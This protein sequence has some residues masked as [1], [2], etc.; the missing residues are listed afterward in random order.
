MKY[1]SYTKDQVTEKAYRLMDEIIREYDARGYYEELR[2]AIKSV[3][4]EVRDGL[5]YDRTKTNHI[6]NLCRCAMEERIPC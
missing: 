4:C 6:L 2:Y 1:V 3:M 5:K